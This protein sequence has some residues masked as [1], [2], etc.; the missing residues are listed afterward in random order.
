MKFNQLDKQVWE[1]LVGVC[2]CGVEGGGGG[3][4]LYALH[5]LCTWYTLGGGGA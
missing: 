5:L 3:L 1:V 2:V 4:P